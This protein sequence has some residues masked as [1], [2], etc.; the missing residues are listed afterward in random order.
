[1]CKFRTTPGLLPT[2]KLGHTA[3]TEVKLEESEN[4]SHAEL[5]PRVP[6]LGHQ[7]SNCWATH[8][9]TIR[10]YTPLYM[11]STA[12]Y[13]YFS[14]TP[15]NHPMYVLR[16]ALYTTAI[17]Y[18]KVFGL[19]HI[20]EQ[21]IN[22]KFLKQG[23]PR[24]HPLLRTHFGS[25]P[26]FI[27]GYLLPQNIVRPGLLLFGPGNEAIILCTKR[28]VAGLFLKRATDAQTVWQWQ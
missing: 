28:Q 4:L 25:I 18:T 3:A 22:H 14:Y 21:P 26:G 27:S 8:L 20:H 13:E 9:A 1:M 2:I 5:E 6:G 17:N 16:L 7:C 12:G 19:I 24:S 11:S 15:G 10:S 23:R